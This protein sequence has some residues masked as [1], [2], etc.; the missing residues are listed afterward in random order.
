VVGSVISIASALLGSGG[1]K[2]GETEGSLGPGGVKRGETEG[3]LCPGGVKRGETVGPG[4]MSSMDS[5][6]PSI[7]ASGESRVGVG[8]SPSGSNDGKLTPLPPRAGGALAL[9]Y[10]MKIFVG[11]AGS[12][13]G[14]RNGD[15]RRV[16]A[17]A[18]A[19]CAPARFGSASSVD[20]RRAG[21][22][23]GGSGWGSGCLQSGI[24]SSRFRLLYRRRPRF[25]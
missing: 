4:S 7:T 11:V 14:R 6:L 25:P 19:S 23:G 17:S 9:E 16:S 12:S 24:P 1:V 5:V 13:P 3:S 18:G 20:E 15:S 2:R 10:G 21:S 22:A 8:D